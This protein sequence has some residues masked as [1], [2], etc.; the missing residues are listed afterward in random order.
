M[1]KILSILLSVAM[2]I[3]VFAVA[4][5]AQ[6]VEPVQPKASTYKLNSVTFKSFAAKLAEEIDEP[7]V[8]DMGEEE[9]PDFY[10]MTREEFIEFFMPENATENLRAFVEL[11]F[12]GVYDMMHYYDECECDDSE[13]DDDY[14]DDTP[15][16]ATVDEYLQYSID[17]MQA[18]IDLDKQLDDA[19]VILTDDELQMLADKL[20]DII[21]YLESFLEDPEIETPDEIDPDYDDPGIDDP[22]F[23]DPDYEDPDYEDPF[24]DFDGTITVEILKYIHTSLIEEIEYW[25]SQ[26]EIYKGFLGSDTFEEDLK[27]IARIAALLD[28]AQDECKISY[29]ND[30][31]D[32][33]YTEYEEAYEGDRVTFEWLEFF[34]VVD[35]V[36]YFFDGIGEG[37]FVLYLYADADDLTTLQIENLREVQSLFETLNSDVIDYLVDYLGADCV[38]SFQNDLVSYVGPLFTYGDANNDGNINM[39]DV[40]LIR[41]YIAKQPVTLNLDAAEVTG[42][43]NVNMLDVLLIRKYIAKQPVELGPK[44]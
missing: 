27:T 18:V 29:Y 44:G 42:D 8:D 34:D 14:Y 13:Y 31:Y 24:Y 26:I 23:D 21:A 33:F 36:N 17:E 1:K 25:E 37:S 35:Y 22:G 6:S 12:G 4:A 43:G 9:L 40:L 7:L 19:F 2:L 28:A 32:R 15:A 16:F 41:K 39:L 5:S 10:A 38:A 3:S 20:N 11:F 30:A